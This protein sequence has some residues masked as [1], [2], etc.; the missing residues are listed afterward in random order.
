MGKPNKW[1]IVGI[2]SI[3]ASVMAIFAFYSFAQDKLA[4]SVIESREKYF[5]V[6]HKPIYD[7]LDS[8]KQCQRKTDSA[9]AKM[10]EST[11]KM[12]FLLQEMASSDEKM[13]AS[14]RYNEDKQY[15][16]R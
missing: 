4:A 12:Y 3:C 5:T 15:G 2:G 7:T 9:T 13:R 16:M 10:K 11:D 6:D 1:T 8:I 14:N